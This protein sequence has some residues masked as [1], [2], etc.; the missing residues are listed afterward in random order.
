MIYLAPSTVS[1]TLFLKHITKVNIL[2][3]DKK[4]LKMS[5]KYMEGLFENGKIAFFLNRKP[6]FPSRFQETYVFVCMCVCVW[7]SPGL[8]F[9]HFVPGP[10]SSLLSFHISQLLPAAPQ[11]MFLEMSLSLDEITEEKNN[12]GRKIISKLWRRKTFPVCCLTCQVF[13]KRSPTELMSQN[14]FSY[15]WKIEGWV[16]AG[17]IF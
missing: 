1:S 9:Y 5:N 6:L 17:Q 14:E 2:K 10:Q 7:M 16:N 3:N 13:W 4:L 8:L 11:N 12:K 15:F